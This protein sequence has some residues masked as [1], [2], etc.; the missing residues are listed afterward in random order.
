ME[1]FFLRHLSFPEQTDDDLILTHELN[2]R[3]R[4]TFLK[5]QVT[6]EIPQTNT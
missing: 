4:I 1:V 5:Q 3:C 6:S 2:I